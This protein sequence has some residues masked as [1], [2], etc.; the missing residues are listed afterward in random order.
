MST[1]APPDTVTGAVET[2]VGIT[3]IFV[4]LTAADRPMSV[5]VAGL[6]VAVTAGMC[7]SYQERRGV[8]HTR[9]RTLVLGVAVLAVL[10]LLALAV[11]LDA[12]R[13]GAA[14]GA[15]IVL[16]C[17]VV[18]AAAEFALRWLA[19]RSPALTGWHL[20]GWALTAVTA[21]T[22]LLVPGDRVILVTALVCAAALILMGAVDNRRLTQLV[23]PTP[24]R[25]DQPPNPI[26]EWVRD[27]RRSGR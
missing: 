22:P 12:S 21:L 25:P 19:E 5:M 15:G 27:R 20:G 8:S 14:L 2:G 1:A 16:L 17:P 26:S 6:G 24:P 11:A 9:T 7:H 4:A 18:L 10:A 3:L 13:S 23:G